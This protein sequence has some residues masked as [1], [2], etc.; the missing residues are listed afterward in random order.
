MKG[1]RKNGQLLSETK[2]RLTPLFR[3]M[4]KEDLISEILGTHGWG[5]LIENGIVE[6][7]E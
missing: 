1:V 7:K 4:S 2:Y 6:V 3:S 5:W